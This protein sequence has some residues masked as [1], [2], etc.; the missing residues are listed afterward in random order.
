[1]AGW[2]GPE[3]FVSVPALSAPLVGPSGLRRVPIELLSPDGDV[4]D[5][6][7]WM[8]VERMTQRFQ[9]GRGRQMV[10][11]NIAGSRVTII[12]IDPGGRAAAIVA[13]D[14]QPS[15]RQERVVVTV[16]GPDGRRSAE[17]VLSLATRR[18]TRRDTD[19]VVNEYVSDI[20][21]SA[22]SESDIAPGAIER[23]LVV[24]EYAPPVSDAVIGEGGQVWL[25][26]SLL[27]ES[28]AR[29]EL[30]DSS[31]KLRGSILLPGSMRLMMA[32]GDTLWGVAPDENDVPVL[33][34]I[35]VRR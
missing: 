19:R 21:R 18:W 1:M 20:A 34:E 14:E 2:L 3:G 25:R 16:Y 28:P 30:L 33:H 15:G 23:Q 7:G 8:P 4:R 22:G 17:H 10:V 29:W 31:G 26:R 11:R 13:L 9:L 12:A 27:G 6:L 35:G 24:P 32:A 5:T